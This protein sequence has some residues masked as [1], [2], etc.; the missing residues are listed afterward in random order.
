MPAILLHVLTALSSLFLFFMDRE[1][2]QQIKQKVKTNSIKHSH[3][4]GVNVK[5]PQFTIKVH[6]L[7]GFGAN[8]ISV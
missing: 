6:V 7:V 8:S 1:P 4:S 5:I 2:N 3:K